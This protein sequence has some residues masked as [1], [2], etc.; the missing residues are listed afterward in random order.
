MARPWRIEFEGALYHILSRGNERKNIYHDSEDRLSFMDCLGEMSERFEIA[1]FAYILMDNHYHIL[2]RTNR[3]NLSKGMQWLGATYT[4]RF[5]NRHMRSGHL[6]QGRFKNI[7]VQNDSYLMQL[8]CYIHRNPIRAKMVKRLVDYKWSSYPAYAYGKRHPKWLSLDIILS[9][10]HSKDN[11][12]YYRKKVQLYAKEEKR[13]WEDFHHGLYL[14]THE[15][16]DKL[17]SSFLRD[18]AHSEIPQQAKLLKIT[19]P[20][21]LLK[22]AARTLGCNPT[23]FKISLRISEQ[24]KD[25]RDLLIY[26]LWETG[27]F[28]N[29]EIGNLFGLTY[30]SISHRSAII[31]ERIAKDNKFK[32][33]FK[34]LKSQIK[35]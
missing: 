27:L 18:N 20:E 11:H 17:K 16:V 5:N 33:Q 10:F 25:N 32:R 28:K 4:R 22:K 26:L 35:M 34:Q 3:A 19:N 8:S 6:F 9:Q 15:F 14:G 29:Q 21:V 1:V 24:D 23:D 12:K 30:S 7:I 31:R 2:L 13:L